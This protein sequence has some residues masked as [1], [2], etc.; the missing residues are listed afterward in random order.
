V[1]PSLAADPPASLRRIASKSIITTAASP[2]SSAWGSEPMRASATAVDFRAARDL[3]SFADALAARRATLNGDESYFLARALEECQFT[4]TV[5]EDLAAYSAKQR[6]QFLAGL[7]PEDANNPRRIAA[8]DSVDNTQRCARFQNAK[9]SQKDI[10][11][12]F[13]GAA[14]EG[15]VRAQ[16]RILVASLNKANQQSSSEGVT[17]RVSADDLSSLI[18]LLQTRDLDS[19]RARLASSEGLLSELSTLKEERD[20]IRTRVTD[21]LEQLEALSL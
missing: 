17:P 8:Y 10:D 5:N 1:A 19:M 11:E 20:V 15:D 12:L 2:T 13:Q 3:K 18:Q 14:Q 9:I 6:R 7:T 16:A 21:M 4:T